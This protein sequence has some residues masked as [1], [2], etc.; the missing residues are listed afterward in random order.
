MIFLALIFT[1]KATNY[2]TWQD[3]STKFTS[4][5]IDD[6]MKI[7]ESYLHETWDTCY[8]NQIWYEDETSNRM[9][10]NEDNPEN[11]IV[12]LS[13]LYD[14][15]DKIEYPNFAWYLEYDKN[16]HNWKIVSYGYA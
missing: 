2:D 13:N 15:F 4:S 8:I 9:L 11:R 6:A 16:S 1:N 5:Q 12:L 10:T 7:V 3:D 14:Y